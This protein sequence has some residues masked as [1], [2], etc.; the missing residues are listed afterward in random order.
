MSDEFSDCLCDFISWVSLRV[1]RMEGV[2]GWV[3]VTKE[4]GME[5]GDCILDVCDWVNS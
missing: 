1:W 2:N 5:I 4:F 3:V